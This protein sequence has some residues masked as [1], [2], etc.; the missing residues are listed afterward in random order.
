M[1]RSLDK[2]LSKSAIEEIKER[3]IE[4]AEAD[5]G[6]SAWEVLR[7]LLSA[8]SQ[9]K[10]IAF[11]LVEFVGRGYLSRERS[12]EVLET[13]HAA[14][15]ADERLLGLVGESLDQACDVDMLNAPP[16]ES[17]LF[18]TVVDN[19]A[20]L[21]ESAN[22]ADHERVLLSGLATAARM[23]ARQRDE[24]A[25]SA[26]RRLL[27]LE[28]DISYRHYNLGLLMK[29][30]GRF[31]EG[32]AANQ[33]AA[34]LTSEP[35]EATEWNLGICATGARDGATAL[36]VWMRMKQKIE[37]GRFGLPEGR[38]PTCKVR[39]AERPLAERTKDLDDPGLEETIWIERLSP[40]HGIIRSVLYQRLGIDYGDVVL[41]DGAPIT[42]H[43]YGEREVP[44]FPHLATLVRSNYLLFD[45]A[46]TQDD[47][48]RIHGASEDLDQDSVIYSH[49]ETFTVLCAGCWRDQ[50]IDH[51]HT[52]NERKHVVRGRIAAPP[53]IAPSELLRQ[54]DAAMLKRSPCRIYAPDLCAAAG[55][56]DR[57]AIERRRFDML[58]RT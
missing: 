9:Q 42:Y 39:L 52:K 18:A 6:D 46:G 10:E 24:L 34:T 7:P 15:A 37:M 58:Q 55:L 29:T 5:R 54:L 23:M 44:V 49:S 14:H 19:L 32:M 51:E 45:F 17:E 20:V 12:L 41:I 11:V 48:G 21:A 31:H 3:F 36:A 28:P 22:G 27:E 26:C 57:A 1:L 56:A 35:S 25:E 4:Q 38:Y 50:G 47:E 8:Q 33:R 30:R 53:G 43:K 16:P 13:V 2:A 40:C